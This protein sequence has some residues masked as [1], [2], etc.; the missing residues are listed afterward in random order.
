MRVKKKFNFLFYIPNTHLIYAGRTIMHG[1]KNAILAMGYNLKFM[2]AETKNQIKL[3]DNYRPDFIFISLNKYSLKFLNLKALTKA[4]DNGAVVF[5]NTPLW[6]SPISKYRVNETTNLKNDTTLNKFIKSGLGDIYYNM[7]EQGDVRMQDFEKVTGYKIYTVPLAADDTIIYPEYSEQFKA[8]VS[9][10][11]TNLSDKR[12]SFNEMLFPLQKKYDLKLYGQDW[13]FT[14]RLLG[15]VGRGGQYLNLPYFKSFRKPKLNLAD[16]RKI[17]SSSIISVNIHETYQKKFGGDCNERTFK[18]PLAGGFEITDNV[19][20]IKKYFVEDRE[21]IIAKDKKD[22]FDK[23]DYYI[24]NPEKRLKII[25]A[26]RKK[27]LQDHTYKH[28]VKQLINIA[29]DYK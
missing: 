7:C 2:T 6:N 20:C 27:V 19:E 17:Y 10:I 1:Y 15:W 13:T 8:D 23:I 14:D 4:K 22:W 26:G 18:V 24:R 25:E 5:V 16:E 11:G 21:I 12:Q 9:F 28:R 3:I 29:K